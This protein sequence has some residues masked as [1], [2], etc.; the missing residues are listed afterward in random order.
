M[1]LVCLINAE[2]KRSQQNEDINGTVSNGGLSCC[3]IVPQALL[4]QALHYFAIGSMTNMV[5]ILI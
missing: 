3:P 1:C 4:P 2:E 5:S